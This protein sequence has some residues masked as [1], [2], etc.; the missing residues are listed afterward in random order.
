LTA[1]EL[2]RQLGLVLSV[3]RRFGGRT[4]TEF[5]AMTI[6]QANNREF[7]HVIVIWPFKVPNNGEQKRRLLYNGITRAKRSC[8]VLVQSEELL[9]APPFTP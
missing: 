5:T 1:D 6:Q 2:R 8:T 3:R 4:Q 7:D 9:A